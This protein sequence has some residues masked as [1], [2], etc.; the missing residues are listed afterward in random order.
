M[1][2]KTKISIDFENPPPEVKVIE[3][4][5][6][7][8]KNHPSVDYLCPE[9]TKQLIIKSNDDSYLFRYQPVAI[10]RKA[11]SGKTCKIC[12]YTRGIPK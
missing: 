7:N 6:G 1:E 2:F 4:Q 9:H 12:S 11:E 10:I 3:I 8:H 5:Y